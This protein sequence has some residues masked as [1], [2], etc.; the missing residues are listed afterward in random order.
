MKTTNL[1]I[2]SIAVTASSFAGAARA[3]TNLL[4][5]CNKGDR[6]LSVINPETGGQIAV[7]NEDGVTGHEV[8]A[9]ADGRLAFVPIYGNSGVGHPGTDGQLIRVIDI[10]RH[11]IVGTVN[12]TKGM[13]AALRRNRAKGPIALRH[14]GTG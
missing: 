1:L 3:E 5:V 11:S 12:F 14:D 7:V 6:T 10:D 8:V 9:S 4:L 2:L 13:R